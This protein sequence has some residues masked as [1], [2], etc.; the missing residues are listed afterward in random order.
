MTDLNELV[1]VRPFCDW[2]EDRGDVLWWHIPVTE[3]P[4]VGSPRD[5]GFQVAARLYNQ[6]GE[7]IGVTHSDVGG[8]PF[9]ENDE[10]SLWW[11]PLP[12]GKLIEDQVPL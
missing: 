6:F 11:T 1:R 4:Y 9:D 3:A 7:E 5:L 2:H 8:W 10:P 12:D